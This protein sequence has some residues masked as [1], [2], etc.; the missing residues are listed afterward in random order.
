[1]RIKKDYRYSSS[2]AAFVLASS[3]AAPAYAQ[4]GAPATEAMDKATQ[5]QGIADIIVT[6][7]RREASVQK[8]SLAISVVD[9]G[10]LE[11][12]GITQASDIAALVPGLQIGSGGITLQTYV[13]GVGDFSSSSLGQSAVAYNIDGIY[14]ADTASISTHFYDIARVE[15]LKGPQ[16]TLYGRNS[17]AG[18]MNLIFNH[19]ELGEASGTGSVEFGNYDA[20]HATLAVNVP[21]GDA[22]AVRASGNY[23]TR[24]GYL[25]DGTN[26]DQQR[27]GRLQLLFAPDEKLSVRI[28][29]DVEHRSGR[30]PGA[31]LTPRQ[32]GNGKF[33]GAV[34]AENNAAL[35]AGAVLPPFLLYTPGAGL[36]PAPFVT[37]GLLQDSFIDHLQRNV[38]AEISYDL[39]AVELTYLPAYR[40]SRSD[41]GGYNSGSPFLN[42]EKTTEQSH[43]LRLSHNSDAL[44]L[45]AGLYYLHLKQR[46]SAQIYISPIPGLI[47]EQTAKLGT[48]SYAAFGQAT[49]H[50]TDAFRLIGGARYTREDRTIDAVANSGTGVAFANGK[51]FNSFSFRAGM[52]DDL[53][54]SN[55]AYVTVS[56]GFKSGGF[57][58]F[59]P[60]A[61]VTNA[62]DPETLYSYAAGLRNRFL[63]NRVQFNIEGFYWDY[64]DSQQ[65]RL[66]FTPAGNL[67]FS[68]FNAASATLYG[69]DADL[70]VKPTP[71]DT[72]T[73]T[74][75]YLHSEFD[76]FV[77]EVPLFTPGTTGCVTAPGAFGATSIDC[78]GRPLPRA[79]RWSG[80]AGYQHSFDL[81]DGSSIVVG[82]D[83]NFA[84]TRYLAVDYVANELASAYVRFN[85]QIT[86]NLPADRVSVTA[87]IKNI[88]NREVHLGGVQ[89]PFSPGLIYDT[90]DAPR[91][92]GVRLTGRF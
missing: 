56:K 36:P 81:A 3:L 92:Y 83:L 84:S 60:T 33:T 20:L 11:R 12:A 72:F 39:G 41:F 71:S 8:S 80:T 59:E 42:Q 67:Q 44:N 25:S 9:S 75:S 49:V 55:M 34:D 50:L 13:R 4:D 35:L 19:P 7:E 76:N 70:I 47:T 87:F 1:M 66:A 2:I 22:V 48:K 88:G 40:W 63:D 64:K 27:G 91:T 69:F 45:V 17:S 43:E 28:S 74:I 32:S 54:P 53:T 58:I 38:N 51:R 16:G 14:V 65:N 79:P 10:A 24:D 62:Y 15:L 21:L 61:S 89:A 73:A 23:V 57:N 85:A 5:Q 46:T 6:A 29:G 37:T 77:Y 30:G 86:Y 68:T 82:G 52:E 78:S 31:V 90:V 26:D 18:A